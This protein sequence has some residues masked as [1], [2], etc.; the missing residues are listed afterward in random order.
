MHIWESW[1]CRKRTKARRA[2][3][4]GELVLQKENQSYERYTDGR[5]GTAG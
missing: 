4:M 3:Q 1:Y 2:T 5:A